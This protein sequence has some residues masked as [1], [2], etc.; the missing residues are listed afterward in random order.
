MDKACRMH[1]RY[2]KCAYR[3]LVGKPEEISWEDTIKNDLKEIGHQGV[4]WIHVAQDKSHWKALANMV[5][6]LQIL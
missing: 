4:D 2:E 5:K 1:V 6:N 3:I